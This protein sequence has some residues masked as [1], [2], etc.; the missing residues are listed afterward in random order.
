MV[1]G[2]PSAFSPE[3]PSFGR[4]GY[5]VV[6]CKSERKVQVQVRQIAVFEPN[7]RFG[8]QAKIQFSECVRTPNLKQL[9]IPSRLVSNCRQLFGP[10]NVLTLHLMHSHLLIFFCD[11]LAAAV[12]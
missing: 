1:R 3:Y 5:K 4:G 6:M 2:E 8:V 11:A 12:G 9:F 10:F 7:L